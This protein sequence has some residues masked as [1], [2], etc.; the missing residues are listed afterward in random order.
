[1]G[2]TFHEPGLFGGE[3]DGRGQFAWTSDRSVIKATVILY[4][5]TQRTTKSNVADAYVKIRM[6]DSRSKVDV[7]ADPSK[8]LLIAMSRS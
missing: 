6:S 8:G 1:M 5:K 7:R 3:D 2:D 4:P